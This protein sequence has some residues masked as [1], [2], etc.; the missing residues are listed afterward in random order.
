MIRVTQE[1][2]FAGMGWA[3][4][5]AI[6]VARNYTGPSTQRQAHDQCK[7]TGDT[8]TKRERHTEKCRERERGGEA[9]LREE[10]MAVWQV[11]HYRWMRALRGEM[12]MRSIHWS[13][14]RGLY[15]H[16]DM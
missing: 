5:P 9:T 16:S 4:K 10:S 2:S 12:T 14:S 11:C 15:P 7:Y 8:S 13:P 3:T 6:V 1:R